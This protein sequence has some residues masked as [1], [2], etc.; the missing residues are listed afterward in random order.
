MGVAA[1]LR[2]ATKFSSQ[3][4]VIHFNCLSDASGMVLQWQTDV[5]A[6]AEPSTL[7]HQFVDKAV[8]SHPDV[9]RFSSLHDLC[10][11]YSRVEVDG[12][13]LYNLNPVDP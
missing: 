13:G 10:A 9:A 7:A 3:M 2:A 5:T 6:I 4:G 11:H 1:F 8:A 12:V